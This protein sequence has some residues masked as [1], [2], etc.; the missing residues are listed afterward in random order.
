LQEIDDINNDGEIEGSRRESL[1]NELLRACGL[2]DR[3]FVATSVERERIASLIEVLGAL[4]PTPDP[5]VGVD[6]DGGTD[7]P[8]NGCWRMAYTSA[9][10]VLSL[11]ANPLSSVGAIYQDA[12]N[13]PVIVNVIDQ[14]PRLLSLLPATANVQSTLRLKVMTRAKRRSTVRVGLDFETVMVEPK[15]L[16]G[17]VR[18]PLPCPDSPRPLR[19][20]VHDL[21]PR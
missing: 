1:K 21:P 6:G 19:A 9:L 14:N 18:A 8:L 11:A 20:S 3:G 10:D 5:T 2:C 13:L 16:L 12:R 7:V 15:S 4:S 17:Q